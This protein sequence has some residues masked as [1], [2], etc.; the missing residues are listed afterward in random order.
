MA[1]SFGKYTIKSYD[2]QYLSVDCRN[3]SKPCSG[4]SGSLT[5]SKDCKSEE[6]H[7]YIIYQLLKT[8]ISIPSLPGSIPANGW[9]RLDWLYQTWRRSSQLSGWLDEKFRIVHNCSWLRN[10][11]SWLHC[12]CS[13]CLKLL[14]Y[15]LCYLCRCV[16]VFEYL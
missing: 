3:L 14:E 12:F 6:Q 11:R 10:N 4:G 9:I 15:I 13:Y 2:G 1:I 7:F 16:F 8:L 5:C